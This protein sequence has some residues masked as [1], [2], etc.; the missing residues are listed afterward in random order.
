[1][2][3]LNDGYFANK[4]GIGTPSPDAK[5]HVAG[6]DTAAAFSTVLKVESTA[7][8]GS[9]QDIHIYNQYD[10]DI[11]IKFE[12]LGG[13]NYIWQ[14]SNS[15]DALIFSTGGSNRTNDAALILE[16]DQDVIVPN[17]RLGVGTTSPTA[18]LHVDNS[19]GGVLRLSDTLATSDGEKIGGIETGVANGTFFAGINFF[20]HDANDGEIR[21]RT[22]VNNTNTDV[23]TIVDGNVGIGT[24]SPS[25]SHKLDVNG[26]G[27]FSGNVTSTGNISA[28]SFDMNS[29]YESSDQ[30]LQLH[31][32]QAND[33]GILLRSRTAAGAGQVDWQI[34]NQG[35]TGDL[36]FYAYGLGG[37]AFV[38]DRETGNLQLPEYG[39]GTLVSDASGN[40][41]VSSGGGAGGPYLPLSAGSGEILTGD[42]AMNNNI[43]IITKDSSGAFRDI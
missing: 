3:F 10:R 8:E 36:K 21:F 32:N 7:D 19:V 11:G 2:N 39:A 30:Y 33:G 17:G 15:D 28:R 13:E 42:L 5:L 4:V 12:T 41:T 1:M 18:K 25:A 23:M 6:D 16:Q 31:K 35:T 20:R 37:N 26:A 43:G 9:V 27:R 14:D 24:T 40:I 34:V 29:T 22:K 38:L